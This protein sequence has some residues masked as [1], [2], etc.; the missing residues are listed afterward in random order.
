[1]LVPMV[2]EQTSRGERAYDIYSRLLRENIIFLGTPIDDNVANLIIESIPPLYC[3]TV[4]RVGPMVLMIGILGAMPTAIPATRTTVRF[5][6]AGARGHPIA[7]RLRIE[8]GDEDVAAGRV[9]VLA[10]DGLVRDGEVREDEHRQH[11]HQV[12]QRELADLALAE[13]AE[14]GQQAEVDDDR[15][16]DQL[17]ERPLKTERHG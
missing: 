14:R 12:E 15:A 7:D 1:M 17:P 11:Q 3:E 4:D 16:H 9:A 8:P 6:E 5:P 10:V 13:E 2:V